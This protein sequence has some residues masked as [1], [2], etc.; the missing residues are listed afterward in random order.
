VGA[1]RGDVRQGRVVLEV[2]VAAEVGQHDE[3]RRKHRGDERDAAQP[4]AQCGDGV[5]HG[6]QAGHRAEHDGPVDEQGVGGHPVD[7]HGPP[8]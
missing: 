7:L 1:D 2:A 8:P 4:L 5:R 3:D 6:Q